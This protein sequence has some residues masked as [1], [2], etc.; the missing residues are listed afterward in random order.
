MVLL[1]DQTFFFFDYPPWISVSAH[2][3]IRVPHWD[4]YVFVF[5]FVCVCLCVHVYV[6]F[7]RC[8]FVSV[9]LFVCLCVSVFLCVCISVCPCVFLYVCVSVCV[10]VCVCFSTLYMWVCVC[11]SLNLCVCVCVSPPEQT[12]SIPEPEAQKRE[13][14]SICLFFVVVGLITFF[15]QMLQVLSPPLPHSDWLPGCMR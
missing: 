3:C 5:V 14:N 13:I 7:T 15:T 10:C 9:F 1:N 12:F 2:I 8:P 6:C 11:V 4:Y